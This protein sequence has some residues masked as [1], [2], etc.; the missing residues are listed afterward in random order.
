MSVAFAGLQVRTRGTPKIGTTPC[1][2]T[3]TATKTLSSTRIYIQQK[4]PSRFCAADLEQET[5]FWS[6]CGLG[7]G[8][9]SGFRIHVKASGLR[10]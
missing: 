8:C 5:S 1:T 7:F 3:Y 10:A 9:W 6:V 2:G 4:A